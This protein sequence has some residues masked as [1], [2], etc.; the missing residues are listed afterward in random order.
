M[1]PC[2]LCVH[3]PSTF[4]NSLTSAGM[5]E[6]G[7]VSHRIWWSGLVDM[8][9]WRRGTFRLPPFNVLDHHN[10]SKSWK[11]FVN[12]AQVKLK[13]QMIESYARWSV[14]VVYQCCQPHQVSS[15]FKKLDASSAILNYW[16][17]WT[18]TWQSVIFFISSDG[19]YFSDCHCLYTVKQSY[20]TWQ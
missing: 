7:L 18:Q 13:R 20:F 11:S 15:F 17:V 16:A 8:A 6:C 5:N 3:T 9:V 10:R 12:D 2:N 19:L 4:W 1:Q 14:D